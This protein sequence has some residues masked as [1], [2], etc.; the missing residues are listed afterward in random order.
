MLEVIIELTAAESNIPYVVS[1]L[2]CSAFTLSGTTLSNTK[3]CTVHWQIGHYR[4]TLLRIAFTTLNIVFFVEIC[5]S[6]WWSCGRAQSSSVQLVFSGQFLCKWVWDRQRYQRALNFANCLR[7]RTPSDRNTEHFET[8]WAPLQTLWCS[9]WLRL[10]PLLPCSLAVTGFFVP[11][12]PPF[13]WVQT[14]VATVGIVGPAL[15][16]SA[17]LLGFLPTLN[18]VRDSLFLPYTG[19]FSICDCAVIN[20]DSSFKSVFLPPD[21]SQYNIAVFLHFPWRWPGKRSEMCLKLVVQSSSHDRNSDITQQQFSVSSDK[22]RSAALSSGLIFGPSVIDDFKAW[23][24][25]ALCPNLCSY[26]F[27]ANS[28]PFGN[29]L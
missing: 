3:L 4:G 9:P 29:P 2:P 15:S 1:V 8:A 12:L 17:F 16:S 19:S 14:S 21:L 7:Q 27:R 25:M 6:E 11:W 28:H 5:N 23:T 22:A 10:P 18:F 20:L 24:I 13:S 26:T